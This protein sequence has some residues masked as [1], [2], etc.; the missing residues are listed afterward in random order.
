MAV[1]LKRGKWYIDYRVEGRRV[2][3]CIGHSKRLAERALAARRGEI[4]QGRFRLAQRRRSPRLEEAADQY[5]EWASGNTRSARSVAVHL[6]PLTAYFRGRTLRELTPWLIE[7]YKHD[8][9][10]ATVHGRAIRPTTINRELSC[11]RRCVNLQIKWGKAE[12]N[13]VSKVAFF[14]EDGRRE[15]ILAP[16]EIRQL[17]ASCTT[18]SRPFV[19]LALHTGMRLGELLGL[20]WEQVDLRQGVITLMRTKSRKWR[21]IPINAVGRRVFAAVPR[22]GPYVFGGGRPFGAIKT[23]WRAAC[24]RAGLIGL[25][26]HDLRH[27]WASALVERG[28]DLRTVQEL[29]G[30]SSL[31][32]VQ[33][34]SHPTPDAKRRAV[35]ALEGLF[36][37]ESGHQVDTKPQVERTK[38]RVSMLS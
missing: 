2:R 22:T 17:L 4:V 37:A 10:A 27:T 18:H 24:R 30:W 29:G 28:V 1:T 14:P 3:E 9:L 26:F 16:D 36:A 5:L 7:R 31:E 8:R 13:P 21:K 6:R 11:L 12:D 32:L 38:R 33:R 23:A 25:R 19:V 20:T 34:Y 35:G 15:R